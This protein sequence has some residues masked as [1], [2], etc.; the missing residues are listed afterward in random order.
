MKYRIKQTPT[1]AFY[2]QF[3]K[4]GKKWSFF[5]GGYYQDRWQ[6]GF[7]FRSE[8]R[9]FLDDHILDAERDSDDELSKTISKPVYHPY[10]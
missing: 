10:P 1:N 7:T 4:D 9:E 2:P 8:A 6:R 3:S 5:Y